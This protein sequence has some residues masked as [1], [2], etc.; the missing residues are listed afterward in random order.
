MHPV[1]LITGASSGIGEA[2]AKVAARNKHNVVL[3]AR[4]ME[5][6]EA[7]AESLRQQYNVHAYVCA[8]DLS[9]KD[10]AARVYSFC[11]E[12]GLFVEYL[13][14][15]AGFGDFG[16]F[17]QS[18]WK[19]QEEMIAVN[20]TALSH[21]THLFIPAMIK[22]KKGA[23]MNVAS[24]AS[25]QPGPLMNMYYASKAFVLHFTEA[26]ANEL[27]GTGV[28]VTAL[29]PGPTRT[30]FQKVAGIGESPVT[31]GRKIPGAD[32]IANFGYAAM[33]KGT[34]VAVPGV[35]NKMMTSVYRFL[36]RRWLVKIARMI[37][38]RRTQK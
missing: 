5:K 14:N 18:E 21:L 16:F 19:V 11:S 4:S 10:A 25:F 23:V 8:V 30:G 26:L 35:V 29:C 34:I 24:T 22:R 28:T 33:M 36:P 9:E 6:L 27:E 31:K 2:L 38:D 32:E 15:N 13:V 7:L 37:Q 1:L 17:H 3:V 12:S 20:I